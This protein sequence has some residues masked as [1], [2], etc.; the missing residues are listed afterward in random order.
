M[1]RS[2]ERVAKGQFGQS[3]LLIPTERITQDLWI[4][5]LTTVSKGDIGETLERRGGAHM[6]L[7]RAQRYHL[8]LN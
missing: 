3:E 2:D 7:S 1:T 5:R 4:G 6:G 8:E